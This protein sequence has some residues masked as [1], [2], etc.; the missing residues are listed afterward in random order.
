[1]GVVI[2]FAL[3]YLLYRRL[4]IAEVKL[5]SNTADY[6]M[7]L[8]IITIVTLGNVMRL[9]PA[10]G[11]EYQVAQTFFIQFGTFQPIEYAHFNI[12]FVLHLLAVQ[13]LLIVF[14]FSKLL[15]SAGMFVNRWILDRPYV[16]PAPGLPGAK[17]SVSSGTSSNVSAGKTTS[18]GV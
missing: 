9:V 11:T 13:L 6:L 10:Y 4:A 3:I 12:V 17:V 7:L 2:W 14:P 5:V 18:G 15:H 16:E 1:M 8:L